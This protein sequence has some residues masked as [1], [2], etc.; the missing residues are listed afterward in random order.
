[1][2]TQTRHALKGDKFAQA[3]K[4]SVTW[5]SG[6]RENVV[7]WA[8][9][10]AVV[11][12]V[13]VGLLV[14]WNIRRNRGRGRTGPGDG[15][16][17]RTA[18]AA[19]WTCSAGH[20]RQLCGSLQGRQSAVQGSRRQV[21]LAARGGQGPLFCRGHRYR[22]WARPPAAESELKNAAGSWNRNLSNLAKVALA[23]YLSPDGPRSAGDRPLQ[24]DRCQAFRHRYRR[25]RPARSG[26]P[27]CG[28]RQAGAGAGA[29]GQVEGL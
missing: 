14:F 6:H 25:N 24:R 2:D 17:H 18:R 11:L 26:R 10:A 12:V 21:W 20:L 7:R 19:R 28:D 29:L 15:Y 27:L 9:S 3:T 16:L 4:T 5:V 22:N 23:C 13:G 1:M 8:I